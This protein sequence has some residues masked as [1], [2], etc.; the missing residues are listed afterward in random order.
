MPDYQ[1]ETGFRHAAP[2]ALG[3]L[4]VNLG[5]PSE[6]S[7][8]AVR[9]YLAEFLG[10]SRVVEAP[11]LFWWL[12]LN[13][14]ILR[15][16][17]ARSAEAYEK[18]WTE[19]GSPL[20]LNSQRI[21]GGLKEKLAGRVDGQLA[22]ELA[23]SYGAPGI[24]EAL[25]RLRE[26]NVR[27]LIVLPLYPQYSGTTTATVFDRVTGVL[28]QR[29]WVPEFRFINQYH[30]EPDYIRALAR[31]I[32]EHR[33]AHGTGKRLLFSF[34]G[35]PRR[36]FLS[37]DPYHCQ[38]R[39]TARLVAEELGLGPDEWLLSFQSRVGREEWL[40]P[41]T[42]ETL[43]AWG[44]EGLESVDVVCPGFSADCLET[45]EEI[46]MQNRELFEAAGGGRLNYIPC[47]NDR[48]DHIEC[49]TELVRR[50]ASGWPETGAHPEAR[51]PLKSEE[52]ARAMGAEQ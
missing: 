20:L 17:P 21:A 2:D 27:R 23:M 24:P 44:E 15:V 4:L 42:D 38:S 45:L 50:H 5:T 51:D 28:Q 33:E 9:R 12:V 34:H 8:S 29:R 10:D 7:A 37:G 39:K 36:Y 16:R 30:D 31:S 26:Q 41:Y 13:L 22:V 11:R 3:V 18:I 47:L 52:L 25:E 40:R 46:A 1:G 14:V 35:I 48:E 49:L 19:E 43:Q 6:A 32:R